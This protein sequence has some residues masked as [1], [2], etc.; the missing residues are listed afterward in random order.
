MGF[1]TAGVGLL[2]RF[3]PLS[4]SGSQLIR[5]IC[6]NEPRIE[7]DIL[8]KFLFFPFLLVRLARNSKRACEV[9]RQYYVGLGADIGRNTTIRSGVKFKGCL[10]L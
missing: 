3:A 7:M 5:L 4:C 10:I 6:A 2:L 1:N 9:R 8:R